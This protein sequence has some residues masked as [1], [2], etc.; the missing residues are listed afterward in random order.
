MPIVASPI[1]VGNRGAYGFNG[2]FALRMPLW[3]YGG[4]L[5]AAGTID[6]DS[7]TIQAAAVWKSADDGATW[8]LQDAGNAP[9]QTASLSNC[10]SGSVV[11]FLVSAR[12]DLTDVPLRLYSF[13]CSTDT[14]GLIAGGGPNAHW[15]SGLH[16]RS[17]GSFVAIFGTEAGD[18]LFSVGYNGSWSSPEDITAVTGAD[19]QSYD[20]WSC[21]DQDDRVHVFLHD[22]PFANWW[23]C[24][25]EADDTLGSVDTLP[26][27][28]VFGGAIAV[29]DQIALGCSEGGELKVLV[30]TPLDN[31][32]FTLSASIDAT[33]P[34]ATNLIYT[35]GTAV[36]VSLHSSLT[37]FI[38]S[39]SY[40]LVTWSAPAQLY[41]TATDTL[42]PD[43]MAVGVYPA[44]LW[45]MPGEGTILLGSNYFNSAITDFLAFY[46]G[47]F[48]FTPAP[49]VIV[50]HNTFE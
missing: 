2:L 36:L 17:D 12:S 9:D 18:D 29:G 14:W 16:K 45:F 40:D 50:Y 23:H 44:G 26:T 41:D 10:Q 7:P 15:A 37:V 5:Y 19:L 48:S 13:D 22:N 6:H 20:V 38:E 42:P 46:I 30:G 11:Y 4:A 1:D 21:L 47:A 27:L 28:G 31:P 35:Q 8:T 34:D 3:K 49:P 32:T 24:A 33:N 43:F 25:V 39:Q